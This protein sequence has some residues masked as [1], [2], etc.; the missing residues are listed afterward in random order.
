MIRMPLAALTVAAITVTACQDDSE[1]E[2]RCS[3]PD[4]YL[5]AKDAMRQRLQ[6]PSS[7][8]FPALPDGPLYSSGE[9]ILATKEKGDDCLIGVSAWVDAQNAFGATLRT[10]WSA[11]L[12][13]DASSDRW[14]VENLVTAQ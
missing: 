12:R 6:S 4:A 10:Q 1:T 13:Y 8:K 2:S 11:D 5:Q 14:R 7:A 3:K 9:V